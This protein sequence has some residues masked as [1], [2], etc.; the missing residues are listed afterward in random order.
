MAK[1]GLI[2]ASGEA[3][4]I[5]ELFARI[6]AHSTIAPATAKIY[7]R[8]CGSLVECYGS[9]IRIDRI[10]TA[11]AE[12]WQVWLRQSGLAKATVAKYTNCVRGAFNRAVRWNL[13]ESSPFARLKSG[14]QTNPNRQAYISAEVFRS[15]LSTEGDP[16]WIAVFALLRWAGLRCPSEVRNLRWSDMDLRSD[17]MQLRVRSP[18]T[19]HHEGREQ[20]IVPIVPELQPILA[21]YVR[22]CKSREELLF[23]SLPSS[24]NLR[25][26]FKRLLSKAGVTAWPR[27]FQNLRAS[28]STDLVERFPSHVAA[29]WCG[30]TV[31]IQQSAYLIQRDAH[32]KA[33]TQGASLL[34]A[35]HASSA[36]NSTTT[37]QDPAQ[38]RI[39]PNGAESQSHP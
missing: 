11:D 13:L 32:F 1:A 39:A 24:V 22:S 17:K 18:K 19:E 38:H 35:P 2:E 6:Q 9:D 31:A 16:K 26:R 25:N 3:L 27:L 23:P 10:T 14:A 8:I 4:K 15:I 7:S 5:T 30:H 36:T 34:G 12:R 20:R 37:S 33:A 28:F 29:A 21:D